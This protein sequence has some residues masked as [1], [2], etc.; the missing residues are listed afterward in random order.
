MRVTGDILSFHIFGQVIVV[1]NSAKVAKDLFEKRGAIYSD[2][3]P[4]PIYDMWVLESS[5][6]RFHLQL[7]SESIRMGWNWVVSFAR[8]GDRWRQGRRVLD[9]GLRPAATASYL[10][11]IQARTRVFLSR[12][13]E[14]PHQWE[15]HTELY[16]MFLV[17]L[18]HIP[19]TLNKC[20][21]F[22]G[23]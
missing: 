12:L 23:S 1:L 20:P 22:R 7:T 9:R 3:S 17:D 21:A 11:M 6:W 8:S 5:I 10:P 18:H 13:L 2:R 19:E 4:T 16:V 14:N 15:A